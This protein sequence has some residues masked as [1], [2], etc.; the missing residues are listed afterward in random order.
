MIVSY[1]TLLIWFSSIDVIQY[2]GS[3]SISSSSSINEDSVDSLFAMVIIF[4][5]C[6][7][8]IYYSFVSRLIANS[9]VKLLMGLRFLRYIQSMN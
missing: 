5:R 1:L 2:S 3:V 7:I 9:L 8:L 4:N 6:L